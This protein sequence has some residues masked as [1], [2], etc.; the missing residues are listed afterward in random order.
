M[1][2]A[3]KEQIT[4]GSVTSKDGTRIGYKQVG[5]GPGLVLV[6]GAMG[7]AQHFTELATALADAFTVTM[8]DRRG[9]GLSKFAPSD[10][11]RGD[12]T[13]QQ[14]VEDLD[15]VL[16]ETG[17]HDVFGVSAGAIICLQ[18][19]LSLPAI[20]RIAAY[21]PALFVDGAP[22]A[23]VERYEHEM[24]QGKVAAALV[25]AMQAAKLGPPIFSAMPRWLSEPLTNMA[26]KSEEKKGA[27]DYV[28]MRTLAPSLHYDLQ[29]V[30][31]MNDHPE[32]FRNINANVLLLGG[33]K[34]PA[35]LKAGLDALATFVP[36]AQRITFAGLD[37]SAPWNADR[38]GKP[39][40]VADA[41]RRFFA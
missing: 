30:V 4:T 12:Y 26:M 39:G 13:P 27:G 33:D 40:V 11:G 41:L 16:T 17:A 20:Q 10:A 14:E 29:F 32:R 37:H 5:H 36:H 25:S 6:Q 34:S 24:A 15:A 18:A 28:P 1:E 38:G 23:L 3:M 2:I 8:P 21:E 7:T 31:A 22:T 35:Y 19:A 9:R